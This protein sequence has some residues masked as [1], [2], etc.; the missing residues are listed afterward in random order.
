MADE[1]EYFCECIRECEKGMY[2]L[3]FGILKNEEDAADIMQ[4]SI[5]K[6][7]CNLDALRD[8]K[9]FRPWI[10]SIVHNTAIEFIKKKKPT[11]DIESQWD[12]AEEDPCVDT[13]TKLTVWEAV[14]KL[15]LPYR[16]IVILFY[17][18]NC[19]VRQIANITSASEP[20]V[21]QQLLRARKM[22]AKLLDKE[23]FTA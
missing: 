11:V 2:A 23:D 16:T 10:M 9:K 15:K 12:L 19:S 20:A 14:Q 18:E 7:Y 8:K 3:A 17:Y 13:A 1:R 21:R 22:L 4:E 5:I 6:A